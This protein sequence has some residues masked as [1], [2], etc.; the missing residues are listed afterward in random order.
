MK[1]EELYKK[2]EINSQKINIDILP[3]PFG[4]RYAG[5]R[6]LPTIPASIRG[7]Q[8]FANKQITEIAISSPSTSESVR[9]RILSMIHF[10]GSHFSPAEIPQIS[11]TSLNVDLIRLTAAQCIQFAYHQAQ[12][13]DVYSIGSSSLPV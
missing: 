11:R 10:S 12:G 9:A 5:G 4:I 3:F 6:I 13:F 7:L 1:D 8:C 2:E